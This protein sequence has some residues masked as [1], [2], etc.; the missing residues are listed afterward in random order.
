MLL[1]SLLISPFFAQPPTTPFFIYKIIASLDVPLCLVF[2]VYFIT[3]IILC[4]H[5]QLTQI[6]QGFGAS[7]T[8]PQLKVRVYLD[9][10]K[11]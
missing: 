7:T 11:T 8:T 3:H 10:P 6:I 9:F 5:V 4:L 2:C 1:S